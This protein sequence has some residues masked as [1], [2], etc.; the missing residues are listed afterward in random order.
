MTWEYSDTVFVILA[1]LKLM[2]PFELIRL[3][4]RLKILVSKAISKQNLSNKR[5]RVKSSMHSKK[6]IKIEKFK[7]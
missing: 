6:V 3:Y 7:L 1:M 2:K 4:Y 5:S